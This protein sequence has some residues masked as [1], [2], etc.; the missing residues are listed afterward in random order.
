MGALHKLD[1]TTDVT[2]LVVG[3]VD[4]EKYRHVARHRPDVRVVKPEWLPAV[5][6]A[7]IQGGE[8][9]VDALTEQYRLPTFHGLKI[10]VTGFEDRM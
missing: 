8:V 9:D 2:H 5:R 4:S 3:G 10:C 6:D 1:L 7:W